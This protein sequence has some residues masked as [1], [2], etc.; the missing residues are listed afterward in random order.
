LY[1]EKRV[2]REEDVEMDGEVGEVGEDGS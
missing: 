2:E 1:T